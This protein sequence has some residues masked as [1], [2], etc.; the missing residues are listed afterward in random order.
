MSRVRV[1]ELA[2]EADMSS[3]ELADK[4]I[5]A[6]YDIKGHSSTVDEETAESIRKTMFQKAEAA[7]EK[8]EKRVEGEGDQQSTVIKR[9]RTI[10]RRRPKV[11]PEQE[12]GED[13]AQGE[14]EAET[15]DDTAVLEAKDEAFPEDAP[16]APEEL[17]TAD[18]DEQETASEPVDEPES[19]D[20]A[21]TTEDVQPAEAVATD[22]DQSE[23]GDTET[24]AEE[25]VADKPETVEAT[26]EKPEV[27]GITQPK[28]VER[29]KIARV[30]GTIELPTQ[31]ETD[32]SE[33]SR[34]K[35]RR[36][37]S[38]GTARQR[39]CRQGL[40]TGSGR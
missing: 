12:A 14:L 33:R 13:S 36:Q 30:V 21:E 37:A 11:D 39:W 18:T 28:Q 22:A 27:K 16:E 40:H 8:V 29:K 1:Y 10:I 15:P 5:A 31:P 23:G 3:K 4:L 7:A 35:K 17:V 6:G 24:A 2:K 34:P 25:P 38:T 32:R 19:A 26:E 20:Q 9:R